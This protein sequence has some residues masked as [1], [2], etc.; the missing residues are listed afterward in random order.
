MRR[1]LV[2]YN[3]ISGFP[4]L[5]PRRTT[6][7]AAFADCGVI[8]DW[9]E[10][11]K[12]GERELRAAVQKKYDR[13]VVIGGDGSVREVAQALI[14]CK[15]K[16]PIAI[17]PQGTGNMLASSLGIP[18]SPLTRAIAFALNGR[19]ESI[20]VFRV[21]KKHIALIGA[22]QGYDTVLIR[23]APR[24]LKQQIG[25]LAYILSFLRTFFGYRAQR[26]Q[27]VVDGKRQQVVGKL[28]MAINILSFIG[29]PIEA[30]VS[31]H[32][33][34]IDLFVINPRNLWQTIGTG[35][36]LILRRPR[37]QI[38]RLQVFRG[39]RVSIRQRKGKHI[40]IDGD[41]LP[42]K[43]LDIEILPRAISIVHTRQFA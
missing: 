32:D 29:I 17:L 28:V 33:G 13:I 12:H 20:D 42:D 8:P 41:I 35:L 15:C 24:S 23:E 7:K 30:E 43:H 10:T 26:Y 34:W 21:N 3:P 1:V 18:L 11:R 16:T 38:P 6:I 19:A 2:V 31:A 14:A 40:Q 37:N 9:F 36:A 5:R 39:K 22:G 25:S 4:L 27:I